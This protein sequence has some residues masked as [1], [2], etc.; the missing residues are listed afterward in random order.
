MNDETLNPV[1]PPIWTMPWEAAEAAK[2]A[3]ASAAVAAS[4]QARF[5]KCAYA[6]MSGQRSSSRYRGCR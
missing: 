3:S 1:A 6:H 4:G 5:C 2:S